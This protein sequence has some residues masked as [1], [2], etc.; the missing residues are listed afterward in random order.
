MSEFVEYLKEVF[1]K[2]GTIRAKKMFGGYG[3]YFDGV[4]FALVA[5]EMLYLKADASIAHHFESKHLAQFSYDKGGKIIKMSFYLAPEEIFDDR[6][7][8]EIWAKR[9]FEVALRGKKTE[10]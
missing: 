7:E 3:I 1:D 10:R 2:F 8:A 6:D 5:H 4:M 9:S